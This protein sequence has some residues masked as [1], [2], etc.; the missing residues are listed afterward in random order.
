MNKLL[1]SPKF[2][3]LERL[4][5]KRESTR[6]Y[7]GFGKR[8]LDL[9]LSIPA[10]ILLTPVLG[11]L[12]LLVQLKHGSP[13]F[14]R[15]VRPGK[16]GKLFVIYKFRTMLDLRDEDGKLLPN[17][18]RLTSFGLFLRKTS[19]DELPELW[20]VIRG[21]MSWVGP[22]PLL[23]RY[24][25]R[26]TPE[27]ARRHEVLP[28]ITGWSQI[29]GRNTA[30]WETRL[31]MDVWYVDNLSMWL[32]IKILFVTLIKVLLREGTIE[33]GNVPDFWG[34]RTPP[35]DG[36]LIYPADEDET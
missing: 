20:N 2:E 17:E 29:N 18:K 10:L 30:D 7:R 16:N 28:G 34:T 36:I 25:E 9:A 31:A 21:E 23:T 12:A 1:V 22:R 11:L 4:L 15:Q 24:L 32:D 14:F 35:K 8:L 6:G 5:P 33:D 19:L 27:Q 26:Y 3:S 13:V